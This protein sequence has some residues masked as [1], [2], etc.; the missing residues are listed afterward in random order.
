VNTHD[1]AVPAVEILP[2]GARTLLDKG[3]HFDSLA[4]A[5]AEFNFKTLNVQVVAPRAQFYGGNVISVRAEC[6]LAL[7]IWK[8][9][10][11]DTDFLGEGRR[12]E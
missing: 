7:S 6:V 11:T 8:V 12:D 10:I 2:V 4:L 9:A 5:I 1:I 3:A